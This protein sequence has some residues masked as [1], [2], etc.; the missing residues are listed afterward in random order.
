MA[1]EVVLKIRAPQGSQYNSPQGMLAIEA[2]FWRDRELDEAFFFEVPD[3][4]SFT[5]LP[6]P[7]ENGL[8]TA[9]VTNLNRLF[10]IRNLLTQ[11]FGLEI[12]KVELRNGQPTS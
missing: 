11:K 4:E 6:Q 2:N 10:D 1:E 8:Y 5:E 9:C 12:V 3:R 7:D